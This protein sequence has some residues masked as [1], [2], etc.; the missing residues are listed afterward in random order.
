[1]G[2]FYDVYTLIQLIFGKA[3]NEII[4]IDRSKLYHFGYSLKD[5]PKRLYL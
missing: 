4:I 3:F 2:Q 1:M 5:K